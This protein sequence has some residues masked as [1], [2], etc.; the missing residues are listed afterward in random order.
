MDEE[1]SGLHKNWNWRFTTL[2]SGKQAVGYK[3]VYIV[4]HLPNG[5]VERLKKCQEAMA[6]AQTYGVDCLET[7]SLVA[8][9]NFVESLCC[10]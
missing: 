8:Q 3:W 6:N 4:N 2:P 9:L 5:S 10:S 1:M 7:F